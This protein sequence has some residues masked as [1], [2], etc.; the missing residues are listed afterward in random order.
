M[1]HPKWWQGSALRSRPSW[2]DIPRKNP[3]KLLLYYTI[4][5]THHQPRAVWIVKIHINAFGQYFN[6]AESYLPLP[7]FTNHIICWMFNIVKHMVTHCRSTGI[8]DTASWDHLVLKQDKFNLMGQLLA[9]TVCLGIPCV[10]CFVWSETHQEQPNAR[11]FLFSALDCSPFNP[12]LELLE[13][14]WRLTSL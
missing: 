13:F 11:V 6:T 14:L 2:S 4:T 9:P 8:C 12:W 1:A 3:A 10:C 5:I 7:L